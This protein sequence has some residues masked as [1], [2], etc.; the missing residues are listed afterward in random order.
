M[1]V[2]MN[3]L[4]YVRRALSLLPNELQLDTL[5]E[6]I[7][8]ADSENFECREEMSSLL[9]STVNTTETEIALIVSRIGLKVINF[10]LLFSPRMTY[11]PLGLLVCANHSSIEVVLVSLRL[12][13]RNDR[14]DPSIV[15]YVYSGSRA[16]HPLSNLG[17][18]KLCISPL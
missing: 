3:D 11:V 13:A 7:E 12:A 2:T 16:D 15:D 8:A 9:D 1:C 4:E 10:E 14:R 17:T 5:L 6:T 18:R